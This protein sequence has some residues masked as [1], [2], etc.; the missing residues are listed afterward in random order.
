MFQCIYT[1]IFRVKRLKQLRVRLLNRLTRKIVV[2]IL[3]NLDQRIIIMIYITFECLLIIH[4]LTCTID[5]M[6]VQA[7]GILDFIFGLTLCT[8]IPVKYRTMLMLF[9]YIIRPYLFYHCL[10]H[11]AVNFLF[12][13][14]PN[15]RIKMNIE[16]ETQHEDKQKIEQETQ[17]EDKQ[18]IEQETQNEDKQNIEQEI[19]IENK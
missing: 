5:Q 11:V 15:C 19:Q 6:I 3:Y 12:F 14:S 1:T 13:C 17:N 9:S 2:L 8:F 10:Y 7:A 18:N 16:Q 4:T